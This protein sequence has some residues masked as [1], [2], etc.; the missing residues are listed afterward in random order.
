MYCLRYA[1]QNGCQLHEDTCYEA[2]KNRYLDI[3]SYVHKNG[4]PWDE[5]TCANAAVNGHLDG[6]RYA[7]EN[8][9][10][11]DVR[12]CSGAAIFWHLDC[13]KYAHENGCPLDKDTCSTALNNGHLTVF[14]M[15]RKM[16]AQMTN[17]KAVESWYLA[18]LGISWIMYHPFIKINLSVAIKR[19]LK[20]ILNNRCRMV[21]DR[22]LTF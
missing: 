17:H 12:T 20:N 14:D 10:P 3:L 2:A 11:L 9:C 1:Y 21:N 6:L 8:G 7:H 4:C 13:L 5:Y 16:V 18:C 15:L 22:R 19:I